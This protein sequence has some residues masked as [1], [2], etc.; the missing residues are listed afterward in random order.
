MPQYGVTQ[1]ECPVAAALLLSLGSI[2]IPSEARIGWPHWRMGGF[3]FMYWPAV[4]SVPAVVQ[5]HVLRESCRLRVLDALHTFHAAALW[6]KKTASWEY[7]RPQTPNIVWT[8]EGA[9]LSNLATENDLV[10][11]STMAAK[12]CPRLSSF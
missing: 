6:T 12:S 4:P 2:G 10:K 1:F 11:V 3:S 9:F 7:P 5:E 8:K